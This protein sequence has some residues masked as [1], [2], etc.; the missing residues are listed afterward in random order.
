MRDQARDL[1]GFKP[2]ELNVI[3]MR[4]IARE[5][6]PHVP[7][8]LGCADEGAMAPHSQRPV[9]RQTT[10]RERPPLARGRA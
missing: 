9:L 1:P 8:D 3:R 4:D 6:N 2:D 10:D 5:I 7:D